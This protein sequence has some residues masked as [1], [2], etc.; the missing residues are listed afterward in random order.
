M[1]PSI[2]TKSPA[3]RRAVNGAKTKYPA[4]TSFKIEGKALATWA[5]AGGAVKQYGLTHLRIREY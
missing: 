3:Q 2:Q 4:L 5:S 1:K